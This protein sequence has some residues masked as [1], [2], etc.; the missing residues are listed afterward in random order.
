MIDQIYFDSEELRRGNFFKLSSKKLTT[1]EEK[2]YELEDY[3]GRGDMP[4]YFAGEIE[5]QV[6]NMP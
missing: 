2:S 3:I 1:K 4:L 6:K 5:L